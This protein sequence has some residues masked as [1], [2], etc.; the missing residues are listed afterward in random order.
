MWPRKFHQSRRDVVE[1]KN[2]I[3]RARLD[4]G[5]RHAEK[6]GRRLVLSDH[7]TTCASRPAPVAPSLPPAQT[8]PMI[9]PGLPPQTRITDRPP[10]ARN[11]RARTA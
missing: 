8:T 5:A 3:D 10:G 7:D 6:R 9:G 11:A 4:G 2:E 1:R